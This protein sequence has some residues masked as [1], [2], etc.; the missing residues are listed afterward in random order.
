MNSSKKKKIYRCEQCNYETSRSNNYRRH[1]AS[2]AHQANN[3]FICLGCQKKF[4]RQSSLKRHEAS[5]CG[6]KIILKKISDTRDDD[7]SESDTDRGEKKKKRNKRGGSTIVNIY[8]QSINIYFPDMID[9]QD[10][11]K[12]LQT[13]NPLTPVQTQGLM[14]SYQQS[15]H[16]Y[17]VVL[18]DTLQE[19]CY[20]QMVERKINCPPKRLPIVAQVDIKP[21]SDHGLGFQKLS[22][23]EINNHVETAPL[24]KAVHNMV[25]DYYGSDISSHSSGNISPLNLSSLQGLTYTEKVGDVW[26]QSDP[27]HLRNIIKISNKQ[28]YDH[29]RYKITLDDKNTRQVTDYLL[30]QHIYPNRLQNVS[31]VVPILDCGV[32]Y[33]LDRSTYQIYKQGVNIGRY[34]HDPDCPKCED[35]KIGSHCWYYIDFYKNKNLGIE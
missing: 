19:N 18:S 16:Q 34:V 12:N 25:Q 29:H 11:I 35:N 30:Y 27:S 8:H 23:S 22:V 2:K 13:V 24:S 32:S 20:Q 15:L 26:K 28:V 17:S 6:K 1:L 9:I 21:D 4:S 31:D 3:Q 7:E 10:F 5:G 33:D 14:V